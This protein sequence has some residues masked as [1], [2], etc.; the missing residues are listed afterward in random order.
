LRV[1]NRR[2][3]LTFIQRIGDY[4]IGQ[5][6]D[7]GLGKEGGFLREGIIGWRA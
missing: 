1:P 6:L 3:G 5:F 4:W 2:R 7:G